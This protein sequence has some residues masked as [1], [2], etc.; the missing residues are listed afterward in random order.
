MV[1]QVPTSLPWP[2]PAMRGWTTSLPAKFL[3]ARTPVEPLASSLEPLCF[4]RELHYWPKQRK[5]KPWRGGTSLQQVTQ[6]LILL[7]T[8][9]QLHWWGHGSRFLRSQTETMGSVNTTMVFFK[10]SGYQF[11]NCK[12]HGVK[13][14]RICL[15]Q[16]PLPPIQVQTTLWQFDSMNHCQQRIQHNSNRQRC[17]CDLSIA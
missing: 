12:T 9:A 16:R 3:F 11:I 8:S 17:P 6:E 10:E 4:C 14:T 2:K 1:V 15:C 13:M 7:L 5:C